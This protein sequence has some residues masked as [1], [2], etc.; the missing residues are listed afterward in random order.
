[1]PVQEGGDAGSMEGTQDRIFATLRSQ[2][3]RKEADLT[4]MLQ[5]QA[6]SEGEPQELHP[7]AHA[8]HGDISARALGEQA[9]FGSET[10]VPLVVVGVLRSTHDDEA[11]E[12]GR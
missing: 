11:P 7:E 10:R 2:L 12:V 5:V 1:M 8:E 9:S 4:P 3:D 6:R